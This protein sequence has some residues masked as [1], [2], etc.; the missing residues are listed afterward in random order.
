LGKHCGY[1]V[2]ELNASDDRSAKALIAKIEALGK[3]NSIR[4]GNK[5]VLIVVD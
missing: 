4:Q 5:P 1:D 2:V 3:S